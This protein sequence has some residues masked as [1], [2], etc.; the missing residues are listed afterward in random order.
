MKSRLIRKLLSKKSHEKLDKIGAGIFKEIHAIKQDVSKNTRE[1]KESLEEL[2]F[3]TQGT[4]QQP[5][6]VFKF[7]AVG[8]L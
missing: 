7:T 2:S 6:F 4:I 3:A 1:T 5:K 8:A